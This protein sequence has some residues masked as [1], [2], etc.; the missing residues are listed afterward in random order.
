MSTQRCLDKVFCDP[1]LLLSILKNKL[2]HTLKLYV[3]RDEFTVAHNKWLRDRGDETLRFDYPLTSESIV[4]DLGGYKGDFTHEIIN[5]YNCTVYLFEPVNGFYNECVRRFEGNSKVKCFNYGLSSENGRFFISN[6]DDAS[7]LVFNDDT[8][9]SEEVIVKQFDEEFDRLQIS[10]I[11]LMKINVEGAE[12]LILPHI[13][14]KSLISKINHLQI[15][16]HNF[17]PD[18]DRLR[19]EIRNELSMT[20]IEKWNYPFVWE[21]WS[22][23]S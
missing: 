12:F 3:M 15:Q 22:R 10:N 20:H 23:K 7:S 19:D 8:N 5:K 4:F 9:H 21:S 1:A 16:F 11:D 17:Y 13:I 14:S 2:I 6:K 18:S